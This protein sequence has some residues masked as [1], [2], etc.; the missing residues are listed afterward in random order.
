MGGWT[1][2]FH[3]GE[4]LHYYQTWRFITNMLGSGRVL[5]AS[6]ETGL[7]FLPGVADEYVFLVN[8][9]RQLPREARAAGVS[10]TEEEMESFFSGNAKRWLRL[11]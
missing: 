11:G 4:S 8:A 2:W 9:L 7:R 1:G 6:D 3:C 5:L 10:F